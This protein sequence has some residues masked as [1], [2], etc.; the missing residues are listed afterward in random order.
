[1]KIGFAGMGRMGAAMSERLVRL[2]EDVTVWNRDPAKTKPVAAAG[3]KVAATPREL[4]EGCDLLITC[5]ADA[6]AIDAVYHGKDGLLSGNVAGKLFMEMSTVRPGTQRELAEK[7]R[8]KGASMVDCPVGGSTGPARD[9]KLIGFLGGSDA[10]V[11]RVMPVLKKLCRRVEHM[12]PV[13]AGTSMKLT[14]NLPLMVYWQVLGEAL[15]LSQHLGVDPARLIDIIS[16]TSAGPNV[17]KSRGPLVAAAL[18]GKLPSDVTFNIDLS[19][20]DIRNMIDEAQSL[21]AS[22][23]VTSKALECYDEVSRAG[24]GDADVSAVPMSWLRKSGSKR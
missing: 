12:G 11:A 24:Y 4:A 5:V 6:G 21:G 8:A 23:P 1:M 14:I 2:G 19:R 20:K 15:S 16:D 9:G 17:L 3:A 18:G 22:A 13:G 7:V 10:D